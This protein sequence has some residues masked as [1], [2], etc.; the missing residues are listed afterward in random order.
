MFL[1]ISICLGHCNVKHGNVEGSF[2]YLSDLFTT[3]VDLKWRW[4]LFIFCSCYV[5]S[6]FTFALVW[7]LIAYGHG[8]IA[9]YNPVAPSPPALLDEELLPNYNSTSESTTSPVHICLSA[10]QNHNTGIGSHYCQ[11]YKG[12]YNIEICNRVLFALS[13]KN[14]MTYIE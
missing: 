7:F 14:S 2:R 11:R 6:W 13:C 5:F 1:L 4:N 3:L 10:I 9:M 8:D 12:K